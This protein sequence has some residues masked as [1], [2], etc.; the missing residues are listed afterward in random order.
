[1]FVLNDKWLEFTDQGQS[2]KN[3]RNGVEKELKMDSEFKVFIK[4]S[5]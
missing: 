2:L 3:M 4:S 5:I 1:M